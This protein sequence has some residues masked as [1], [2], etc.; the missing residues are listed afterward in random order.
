MPV[1]SSSDDTFLTLPTARFRIQILLR[2]LGLEI[3]SM[4]DVVGSRLYCCFNCRNIAALHDDIVDRNFRVK[5]FQ[6]IV[7]ELWYDELYMQ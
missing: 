6:F 2:E 7:S 5:H 1:G 4:D 3:S